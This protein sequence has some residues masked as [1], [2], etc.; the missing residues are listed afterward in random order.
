MTTEQKPEEKKSDLPVLMTAGLMQLKINGELPKVN[1]TLSQLQ[2]RALKIIKNRDN[3][4]VMRDLLADTKKG[5]DIADKVFQRIKKPYW[6]AG[7]ACDEGKK[8]VF[9]EFERIDGMF[10]SYYDKELAEIA[11]ETRLAKEK[12]DRDTAI[13]KGIEDNLLI[14]SNMVIT[15]ITKKALTD[16]ESRINLEKS[17]LRKSKYGERHQF[18]IERYD[19]VLLPIIR[20]QKI[21]V[22]ELDGINKKILE[23]E[24]NNDPDAMDVLIEKA[25]IKSNEILQNHADIQ[26]AVLNQDSFPIV[27]ATEILPEVKTKRTN[28]NYEIA[29][30]EVAWKKARHL[31]EITVDKE[32][33]KEVLAGLKATNA[34]D[35][36]DE[37]I[38][39]GIKYIA[40]RVR[41]AL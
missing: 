2:E 3:L 34:F 15:A 35:G 24:A 13:L 7:K 11:E 14:F 9:S 19:T 10:K 22:E 39:D 16:V 18:A 28:Y 37:V 4:P 31:L 8:L 33:A 30:V 21:K 25:D 38:V 17:P 12:K 5:R 26:E 27:E 6:D 40:T 29:D 36:K 41:E 20:D 32:A 23:A 1:L